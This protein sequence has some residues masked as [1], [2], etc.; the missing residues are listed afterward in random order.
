V[1][2]VEDFGLE[3]NNLYEILAS[4]IS[5]RDEVEYPN[6]AAMGVRIIDDNKIR[7]KPYFSS[8]TYKNLEH[9]KLITINL[10]DDVYLFALSSLKNI[11][12]DN[13]IT[14]EDYIFKELEL[15]DKIIRFPY[16]KQAWGVLFC[17]ADKEHHIIKSDS[18]GKT[19]IA[20]FD[21]NVIFSKI[22]R[23][24]HKNFNRAENLALEIVVL[25]SRLNVAK[26]KKDQITV[27]EIKKKINEYSEM[28]ERFGKNKSAINTINH[29]RNYMRTF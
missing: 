13:C 2:K 4:T 14:D 12:L 1:I 5:K 6:T 26:E 11:T 21:L 20:E 9:N 28:I 8:M 29:V 23:N 7:I 24:S 18:F 17:I 25:A 16:L 22:Y 15:R 27:L 19:K 3:K 10:I